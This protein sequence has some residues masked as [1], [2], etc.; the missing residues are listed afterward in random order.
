MPNTLM[1]LTDHVTCYPGGSGGPLEVLC[2]CTADKGPYTVPLQIILV[3]DNVETIVHYN[4]RQNVTDTVHRQQVLS[5]TALEIFKEHAVDSLAGSMKNNLDLGSSDCDRD[6]ESPS[7]ANTFTG[8]WPSLDGSTE[9]LEGILT[10]DI[11]K[12]VFTTLNHQALA[13]GRAADVIKDAAETVWC[14]QEQYAKGT[15]QQSTE[16]GERVCFNLLAIAL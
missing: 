3:R 14:L 6:S 15:V 1:W 8:E 5:N 16:H 2:H 13:I 9:H 4:S 10:T 11:L 12:S 7:F